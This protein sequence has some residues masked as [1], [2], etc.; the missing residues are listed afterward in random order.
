MGLGEKTG[1]TLSEG[2]SN[3]VSIGSSEKSVGWDATWRASAG[4]VE[5][6]P[7]REAVSDLTMDS[8]S[9]DAAGDRYGPTTAWST[10]SA[11]REPGSRSGNN[12]TASAPSEG[13]AEEDA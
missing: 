3:V 9:G 12:D 11:S 4:G 10:A 5:K 1:S 13:G 8:C 2:R 7:M 6:C